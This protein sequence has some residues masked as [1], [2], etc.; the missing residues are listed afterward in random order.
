MSGM[1]KLGALKPNNRKTIKE[2]SSFTIENLPPIGGLDRAY[3]TVRF[4]ISENEHLIFKLEKQLPKNVT[5]IMGNHNQTTTQST[6]QYT[7]LDEHYPI[8]REKIGQFLRAKAHERLKVFLEELETR[9]DIF[10]RDTLK[11]KNAQYTAI[12]PKDKALLAKDNIMRLDT[13][14]KHSQL[15]KSTL[16]PKTQK[17]MFAE[18]FTERQQ[19][20]LQAASEHKGE[21][22]KQLR[23]AGH[24]QLLPAPSKTSLSPSDIKTTQ[25]VAQNISAAMTAL[26]SEK[27]ASATIFLDEKETAVL[28]EKGGKLAK[29]VQDYQAAGGNLAIYSLQKRPSLTDITDK[30]QMLVYIE[31]HIIKL[32][33]DLV[34]LEK[35]LA[36]KHLPSFFLGYYKNK[37][38]LKNNKI[39]LLKSLLAHLKDDTQKF[40]L[41]S[42]EKNSPNPLEN[43]TKRLI[44]KCKALKLIPSQAPEPKTGF[45]Q[46]PSSIKTFLAMVERA[47]EFFP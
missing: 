17:T 5:G 8:Q 19:E 33:K 28:Q 46:I 13:Q 47:K 4:V 31:N 45:F 1:G 20:Y 44:E 3:Q 21:L 11:N 7:S 36:S 10:G 6:D 41:A 2:A 39:N 35:N 32:E 12:T 16:D 9:W 34:K 22:G 43:Y 25:A 26:T 29:I 14:L 23:Q 18:C 27:T 30:P 15:V 40:D 42:F 37:F 24:D 38:Q